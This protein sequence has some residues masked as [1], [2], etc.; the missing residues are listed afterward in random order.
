VIRGEDAGTN[1]PKS[2]I[3]PFTKRGLKSPFLDGGYRLILK[4]RPGGR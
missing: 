1:F 3:A 4:D 2:P